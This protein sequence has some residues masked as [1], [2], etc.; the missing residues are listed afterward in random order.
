MARNKLRRLVACLTCGLSLAFYGA[1]W[2]YL[3]LALLRWLTGGTS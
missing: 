1:A 3:S 2:L